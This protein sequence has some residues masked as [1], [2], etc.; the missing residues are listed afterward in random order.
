MS[1]IRPLTLHITLICMAISLPLIGTAVAAEPAS[2]DTAKASVE[3]TPVEEWGTLKKR[4]GEI[5]DQVKKLLEEFRNANDERKLKVRE[6][7]QTLMRE[8]EQKVKPRM[9]ELAPSIY[10]SDPN[11]VEAGEIFL[12]QLFTKN[13]YEQALA[14]AN[15][16]QDAGRRSPAVVNITGVCHFAV[17]NFAKAQQILKQAE[18]EQ[19]LIPQLGGR[20]LEASG[21]YI[22]YWQQEQEIRKREASAAE[23]KLLPR[24][25]L[26]TSRGKI[27]I[28]LF[29]NEAPNTVANFV[30]LV[31][32]DFYNGTKFHRIIPGF[33][34]QGGDP[35]SRGADSANAG[36]G[37]PGHT[38][39][40]ECYRK[41]ARKHFRGSLSMA[42]A[43]RDSG[44]SQFFLTHLPTPHLNQTPAPDTVHT[45]FGRVIEG[46]DIVLAL[47]Q[48]DVITKATVVRKRNHEYKPEVTPRT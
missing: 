18:E 13:A 29:E 17:H 46:M 47:Q 21:E 43:G 10:E 9:S 39:K 36:S 28:E 41:D 8:F 42:H 1:S 40:C 25:T 44:G 20:Y 6:E 12:E 24:V 48:G 23:D 35:K 3:Q 4:M 34:A 5:D 15:E 7:F 16:L 31:E 11:D 32:A 14:L 37:G 26:E 45:V 38:I 27:T 30:N 2:P 22:G 19:M 33:M